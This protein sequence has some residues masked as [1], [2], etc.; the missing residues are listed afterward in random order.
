MHAVAF[1]TL[2]AAKRLRDAGFNEKQSD[3]LV[4]AF[5]SNMLQGLAGKDD[6]KQ[7]NDSLRKD[8]VQMEERVELKIESVSKDM[9]QMG[10]RLESKIESVSKD[11]VQMGERLESKIESVSKDM[12]QMEE[13]LESK[14]AQAEERLESRITQT[15]ERLDAR[16]D[17]IEDT[18]GSK[19]SV[20][21][22]TIMV[23]VFG[24]MRAFEYFIFAS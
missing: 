2:E 14:I 5:A 11:M 15:E 9:V 16:M 3:A 18:L 1:D 10:E 13:R 17:R 12:V 8:I 6:V 21:V 19:L 7:L 24:A 22:V 20:R 23:A 4:G